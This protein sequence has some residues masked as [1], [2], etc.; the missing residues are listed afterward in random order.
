M[1][2]M[3]KLTYAVVLMLSMLAVASC[4]VN[5]LSGDSAGSGV[6]ECG[7]ID[8]QLKGSAPTRATTSTITKEEAD[9][10]LVS[11]AKGEDV[12]ASQKQLAK[13]GTMSFPAGYGYRLFVESITEQDAET[14][15]EGWGAKRFTGNS[16]SFGIQA[17]QTT[18][19]AVNCTVANAAV[20]VNM[21]EGVEGCTVTIT[22]GGRILVTDVDGKVAYFNVAAGLTKVVTIRIEK[23]GQLVGEQ[24]VVLVAALVK[25][26]NLRPS[27]PG[28]DPDASVSG[29][30]ISY[31]DH[32][33][34]IP[35]QIMIPKE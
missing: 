14:L 6:E 20:A 7:R 8:I 22:D 3:K 4:N 16:K 35:E 26:V 32:F 24:T 9:L 15:N 12:V 13:V 29:M 23:N 34:V 28:T 21:A 5:E 31:D 33:D 19:V 25:D 2:K 17:G 18:K 30:Q 27:D 11:I 10:F 1:Y